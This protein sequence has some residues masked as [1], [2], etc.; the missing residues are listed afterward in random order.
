MA[1]ISDASNVTLGE[2]VYNNVHGNFVHNVHHHVYG[3][4]RH[5][6]EIDGRDV[7][8]LEGSSNKRR[9]E[10]SGEEG[11]EIIL[12]KHLKLTREIGNG[13]G[14]FL[15]AGEHQ[16]RALILKVF[17][18]GP[19][20][21]QRMESTVAL[22]QGLMH[23]N[24][25]RIEGISS[26]T[27]P[28]QFIAYENGPWLNAAGPLAIALKEDVPRSLV[29]GF[30]MIA[31]LASGINNLKVNAISLSPMTV[32]NFDI[33][34]DVNDRF[35]ISIDAGSSEGTT[36]GKFS[37]A[38]KDDHGWDLLNLLC[39]KMFKSANRALHNQEI[40]CHPETLDHLLRQRSNPSS[41]SVPLF[42]TPD[43]RSEGTPQLISDEQLL[44]PRREYVWRT[45][46][47][48]KNCLTT[49]AAQIT[50][51]LEMKLSTLIRV[52]LQDTQSPH[53]CRRYVREEI[54]LATAPVESA[55]VSHDAP[56]PL[57]ICPVCCE[58]VGFHE[59][60]N[61]IC[62]DPSKC[63]FASG[64]GSH[65]V[66]QIL[67]RGT[68]SNA[69]YANSGATSTVWVTPNTSPANPALHGVLKLCSSRPDEPMI[70]LCTREELLHRWP[71][72]S[73]ASPS[74]SAS[75]NLKSPPKMRKLR[76]WTAR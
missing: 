71:P 64:G 14:Y 6:E 19:S 17:N 51:D 46:E 31:G 62:G 15:H 75:R 32:E 68:P 47:R 4:K 13:S 57:E 42:C 36:S 35:L 22:S 5:R 50:L 38:A 43:Q 76:T 12:A 28:T 56:S 61:C 3:Q 26:P 37:R 74:G 8:L 45:L 49:V 72:H 70:R 16:G 44:P 2:G 9:R 20:A 34:L 39:Q 33:F 53:R 66:D 54:T 29:L 25:L 7:P 1:F 59:M 21:R 40:E 52:A 18:P 48:G 63:V 67:A 73:P 10:D 60:L 41:S 58:V 24:V 11:F 69:G 27:S 55:V 65:A 23:P 30:R